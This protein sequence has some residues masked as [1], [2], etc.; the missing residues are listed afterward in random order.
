MQEQFKTGGVY[1]NRKRAY[2]V[3]AIDAK[4]D[5]V[6][7][8]YLDNDTPGELSLDIQQNIWDNLKNE[9]QDKI[10]A[11]TKEEAKLIKNYGADFTGLTEKDF[12]VEV[13][14]TTWRDHKSLPG[15]VARMLTH[16]T[17]RTFRSWPDQ[18]RPV[19]FLT[20]NEFFEL[21][22]TDQG[23]PRVK[24]MIELDES[25]VYYGLYVE[26]GRKAMDDSWDWPRVLAAIAEPD[27]AALIG[28]LETLHGF[29]MLGRTSKGDRK[30]HFANGLENGAQ[31]LWGE[32]NPRE[33]SVEERLDSLNA[34]QKTQWGELYIITAMPKQE[35][36][37]Q[38]VE[39]GRQ[40][41][42]GLNRLMP[43]FNAAAAAY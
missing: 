30:F 11:T 9:K 39:L 31:P 33:L 20:T 41:A 36:I 25:A 2:E 42:T 38:R 7:V 37:Q 4:N 29:R 5:L 43:L 6:M 32:D 21:A 34:I 10:E 22:A 19:A 18:D 27:T 28:K 26:H 15:R 24:F 17:K 40:I 1:S 23:V 8:R 16:H 13:K 35:A 14:G 12:S 3:T